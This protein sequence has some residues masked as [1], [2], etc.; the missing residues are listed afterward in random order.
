MSLFGDHG[1]RGVDHVGLTV[2]ELETAVA[3]MTEILGATVAFRHGPYPASSSNPRQFARPADSAVPGIVML[4]LGRMN[5]ELLQFSSPS[6]RTG[7]PRPDEPGA[8]HIALYVDD[9]DGAMAAAAA[10]G[11]DVL[12]QA[13]RLPGPESGEGARF[14][15]IRTPWGG[16]VELVS[17]PHGKECIAQGTNALQDLRTHDVLD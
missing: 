17:Y 11:L 13:M 14:V 8:C 10:A 4:A 6:A 16:M 12:G 3:F 2:P 7:A 9:L 15:F 5:I 1:A